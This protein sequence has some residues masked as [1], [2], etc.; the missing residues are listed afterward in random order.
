MPGLLPS[1]S[2]ASLTVKS[3]TG[4]AWEFLLLFLVVIFGPTLIRRAR[5]PGIIGLILGGFVIGPYGL[6]LIGIGNTT[7]PE[8]GQLGLLYLMF[9]AG[10]ELDLALIRVHRRAVVTFG[11]ITFALPMALGTLFGFALS[12]SAPAALLLGSLLSSHTLLLYP[13]VREAGLSTDLGVATAVGATV[14]TDTAALIVLAAVSGSQVAGGSAASIGLQLVVGLAVLVVFSLGLLPRLARLAFGYLGTDRVVRYTLAVAS[15][16]AA[17]TVAESFGIEPIVGAFFAGLALNRLVPN[18]GPLME[19]IDFFGSAVFVPVF[20]VSV[21]LLLNPSVMVQAQTLKLAGLFIAAGIGGKALASL[22]ARMTMGYSTPQAWLMLGLTIPQAAATLA[23]TVVGFNIGLFDQSVVNAVLVLILVS[24]IVGTVIVD[25]AKAKVPAPVAAIRHLGA[26]ILVTVEDP[27][28]APLG[29]AI[30]ARVAAPDS[31]VVRGILACSPADARRRVALLAKLSKAGFAA[32]V[33]TEPRL[34]VHSSL[35]EGTLNAA[36]SEQASLVL[37]GQRSAEAASALGTSAEAVAAATP[38]PVAILMGNLKSIGEV[39]LI[40]TE[41]PHPGPA[42]SDAAHLA[43]E[44][45]ERVGGPNVSARASDSPA[46][47]AE[48]APGTLCVAPATSWQL[49]ASSDPAP[50]SAIVIVLE[51][52]APAPAEGERDLV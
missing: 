52:G 32:G 2:L 45:A 34:L 22:V 44:I 51:S 29:F 12:W 18:E 20:L 13:T 14:L 16:L 37:I 38:V 9:V 49:L 26:H 40:R 7:V 31:G 24:I 11:A 21:G 10:V 39:E 25:R 3:P 42:A 5:G 4:P 19:R 8:L 30:G 50:G 23:A 6:N 48:L 46:W 27:D 35:A 33:D 1:L 41:E 15:F 43:A 28:Q 17:A 36:L 47:P